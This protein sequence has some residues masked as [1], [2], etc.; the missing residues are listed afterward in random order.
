MTSKGHQEYSLTRK[1]RL[2]I[3]GLRILS[4]Q[5]QSSFLHSA[6]VRA[7]FELG[8]V[9]SRTGRSV[10]HTG[11]PTHIYWMI[12]ILKR[13]KMWFSIWDHSPPLQ[14]HLIVQN[15]GRLGV[16]HLLLSVRGKAEMLANTVSFPPVPVFATL[17]IQ[18]RNSFSSSLLWW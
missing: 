7:L 14:L 1:T 18:Q 5:W 2:E 8:G 6:P 9:S 4:K 12:T 10:R 11:V 3:N 15:Q 17:A 13:T 16:F